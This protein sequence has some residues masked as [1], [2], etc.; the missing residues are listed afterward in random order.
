MIDRDALII[1]L[2]AA[3]QNTE[4]D[5]NIGTTALTLAALSTPEKERKPYHRHLERLVNEV[6]SY[7][8][9]HEHPIP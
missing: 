6:E 8:T 2:T 4:G 7:V 9:G 5:L 3:S 1:E